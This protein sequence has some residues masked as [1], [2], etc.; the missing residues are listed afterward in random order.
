MNFLQVALPQF[1]IFMQSVNLIKAISAVIV[2][3]GNFFFNTHVSAQITEAGSRYEA[4]GGASVAIPYLWT[5][6]TNQAALTELSEPEIGIDTKSYFTIKNMT[7]YALAASVPT[8]YGSFGYSLAYFGYSKFNTL[9]TGIAYAMRLAPNLSAGIQVGYINFYIADDYGNKGTASSNLS[10][11]YAL[12]SRLSMG[13]HVYNPTR[14]KLFEKGDIP[15]I[16]NL[17]AAY[18]Y[19]EGG[20]IAA[21]ISQHLQNITVVSMG[22]DQQFGQIVS[23]RGGLST[24]PT[25]FYY[26]VG[27]KMAPFT[28]DMA[29]NTHSVLGHSFS[30][31]LS[32][33]LTHK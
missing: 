10:L 1:F 20:I 16:I 6:F 11:Y 23:V 22:F 8:Q 26:G 12:N 32:Y 19:T 17:G 7:R 33:S 15:T 9:N 31:G 28:V 24:N 25:R 14:S 3:A 5:V 27:V 4:M 21:Q 13:M 18:K 2:F 29:A 30:F